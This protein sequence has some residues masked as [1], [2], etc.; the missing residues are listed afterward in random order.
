MCG[1]TR[2]LLPLVLPARQRAR[3]PGGPTRSALP[4]LPGLWSELAARRRVL[5]AS[6]GPVFC[7]HEGRVAG[8]RRHLRAGRRTRRWQTLGAAADA[9][10]VVS[11]SSF[12]HRWALSPQLHQA[13]RPTSRHRRRRDPGDP[14]PSQGFIDHPEPRAP[15]RRDCLRETHR[16]GRSDS[17]R[18]GIERPRI[19]GPAPERI[20]TART[21]TD[22]TRKSS[23][24]VLHRATRSAPSGRPTPRGAVGGA[25]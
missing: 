13:G 21:G 3:H 16:G 4:L 15:E 10:R 24:R 22:A 12:S 18:P 14:D 25:R 8:I 6:P 20:G 23:K 11:C 1:R 7:A 17:K 19:E 9:L 5:G 2:R